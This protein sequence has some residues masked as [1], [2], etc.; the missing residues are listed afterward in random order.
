LLCN[1]WLFWLRNSK[2]RSVGKQLI[3]I[4]YMHRNSL[5][6]CRIGLRVGFRLVRVL[7]GG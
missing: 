4:P 6:Y 7:L 5:Y 1:H 3:L 2:L